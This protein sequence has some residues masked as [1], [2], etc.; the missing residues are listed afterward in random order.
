MIIKKIV[1]KNILSIEDLEL[2]F[3]ESG[4]VLVDGWNHDENTANAAGKT[5][6]FNALSFGL[7]GKIPRNITATEILRRG[8]KTGSVEVTLQVGSDTW[9]IKRSRPNGLVFYRNGIEET[10]TQAGFEQLVKV[11]YN[12]FLLTTYSSQLK[13]DKFILLNDSGKKDFLLQIVDLEQFTTIKDLITQE[14]KTLSSNLKKVDDELLIIETKRRTLSQNKRDVGLVQQEID[15]CDVIQARI[16]QEINSLSEIEMPDNTQFTKIMADIAAKKSKFDEIKVNINTLRAQYNT[17]SR[18][19]KKASTIDSKNCPHCSGEIVVINGSLVDAGN[20]SQ[21]NK[22]I[23]EEN[24]SIDDQ[25][26]VI[27]QQINGLESEY[28]RI[29]ELIVLEQKVRDKQNE[30]TTK[31]NQAKDRKNELLVSKASLSNKK[32]FLEKELNSVAQID[33]QLDQLTLSATS[34]TQQKTAI[35][36]EL[37]ELSAAASVVAPS[38][39][40]AYVLDMVI[41]Q[42]NESVAAYIEQIWVNASYSLLSYKENKNGDVKAKF[43]ERIMINGTERTLGSLSGGELCCLSLAVDLA[44]NDV[45]SNTCGIVINPLILD[46]PFDGMDAANRER[47]ITMLS[48]VA[49]NKEIWIIDH[50]SEAKAMFS[51]VVRIEKQNGIS[52]LII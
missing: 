30:R 18:S 31:Y 29:S 3:G 4:L 23:Q 26:L 8:T 14:I 5:A 49:V 52:K 46:E 47:A 34:Y 10:I 11:N 28:S 12:Q 16:E 13:S 20:I 19:K 9:L 43:S 51:K 48:R 41:E 24:L 38:G 42:I 15:K 37:D 25:L 27:L 50:N 44:I 17:L 2:E 7:Y 22:L 1:I 33:R 21:Q 6:I 35:L 39:A 32:I 40:P 45:V 36:A